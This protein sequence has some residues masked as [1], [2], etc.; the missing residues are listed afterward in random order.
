MSLDPGTL[1]LLSLAAS[2]GSAVI[3]YQSQ[4]NA[5]DAQEQANN[6][7][8][9]QIQK[10]ELLARSN[11][12]RQRQAQREADTAE[13]NQY[14]LEAQRSRA[15]LAAMLGEFGGGNT[16]ERRLATIGV[17]Q[18]QDLATIQS[19][20]DRKQSELSLNENAQITSIRNKTSALPMVSQPSLAGT[21]LSIAG[22]G[23]QYAD[24]M[25]KINNPKSTS[26]Y[27]ATE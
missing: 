10:E 1:A 20:A 8:R 2:A 17:Q 22:S 7:A 15:A 3:Q 5:A 21:A 26:I 19:N 12:E 16:G 25:N 27:R 11:A 4:A 18:G 24:R 9:E 6:I 23:I 14:A 13:A